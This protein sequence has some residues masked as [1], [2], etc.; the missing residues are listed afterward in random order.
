M[1]NIIPPDKLQEFEKAPFANNKELLMKL[2]FEERD[3]RD[4]SDPAGISE[5]DE[6]EEDKVYDLNQLHRLP[7]THR[8]H[9]EEHENLLETLSQ[10]SKNQPYKTIEQRGKFLGQ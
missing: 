9:K 4:Y 5:G 6:S 7:L 1:N 8:V 10:H 3:S 2:Y